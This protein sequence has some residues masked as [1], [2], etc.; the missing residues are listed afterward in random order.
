[1]LQHSAT[2]YER[3][4]LGTTTKSRLASMVGALINELHP[5]KPV[6]GIQHAPR[7]YTLL[8]PRHKLVAGHKVCIPES[9]FLLIYE[10][11]IATDVADHPAEPVERG[12]VFRYVTEAS[13]PKTCR[14]ARIEVATRVQ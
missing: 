13:R 3:S 1:M 11:Y 4:G 12:S 9:V 10:R 2:W 6:T 14:P 5:G 7:P 8:G